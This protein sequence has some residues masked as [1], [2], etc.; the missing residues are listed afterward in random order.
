MKKIAVYSGTFDPLTLGHVDLVHRAMHIFDKLIIA[1]ADNQE[2]KTFFSHAERIALAQ[3]VFKDFVSVEV[4]GFTG[5]LVNFMR[6]RELHILIRGLRAVS[7][8]D[9]EFQMASMNRM[10]LPN[11]ETLF[12]TPEDKY[13]YIS[14]TLVRVIAANH[15]DVTK[16][17]PYDVA[18]AIEKLLKN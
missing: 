7:D 8:F 11:L 2:K 10:L 13:T 12:L 3:A 9:Y 6:T 16:F 4:V 15:G 1:V 18:K 5:L 17:V 14:S